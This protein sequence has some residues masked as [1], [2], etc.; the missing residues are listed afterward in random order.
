MTATLDDPGI[1]LSEIRSPERPVKRRA[2]LA[3][4]FL[5]VKFAVGVVLC[6]HPLG[7]IFL[8]GWS[9]R[10]MQRAAV[11]C[12]WRHST[13]RQSGASAEE[14]QTELLGDGK[15]NR[16][17]LRWFS[18]LWQT[19]RRGAGACLNLLVVTLPATAMWIFA[20]SLGWNNSFFKLYEQSATGFVIG[21]SG[22][23][24]F[25]A[26]MMYVPIARARQAT[27]GDWRKF[28][29]FRFNWRLVRLSS[30]EL[31]GLAVLFSLASMPVMILRIAPY[32]L[33]SDPALAELTEEQQHGHLAGYFL[34]ATAILLPIYL[35]VWKVAATVYARAIVRGANELVDCASL[36]NIER[37]AVAWLQ[38][39]PASPVHRPIVSRLLRGGIYAPATA[40]LMGMAYF[41]WTTVAIQIFVS[42]FF[43]Y[44]PVLPWL[45]HPLVLLPWFRY[46]PGGL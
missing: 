5:P 37:N 41:A 12:W 38:I 25:S 27:T 17:R 24:I 18:T 10:M 26:V 43:N 4:L 46:I 40:M 11:K 45:N 33:G 20:W 16:Q 13:V 15:T 32:F 34:F 30:W 3:W 22:L 42:Q 21:A 2:W 8:V 39:R 36:A 7:A 31:V 6:Q 23:L 14:F 28:Y 35:G 1:V 9:Q 44:V 19:W 29:D